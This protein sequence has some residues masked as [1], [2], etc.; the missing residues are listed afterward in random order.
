MVSHPEIPLSIKQVSIFGQGTTCKVSQ[1]PRSHEYPLRPESAPQQ[2][3]V[4]SPGLQGN[5][6]HEEED[7]TKS[8]NANNKNTKFLFIFLSI[9]Q[10]GS[11]KKNLFFRLNISLF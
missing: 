6:A 7:K 11:L 8:S 1:K 4:E 10:K 3:A 5:R 9:P 2:L